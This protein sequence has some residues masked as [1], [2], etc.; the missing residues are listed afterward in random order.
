MAHKKLGIFLIVLFAVISA[1]AIVVRMTPSG[2][3]VGRLGVIGGQTPCTGELTVTSRPVD[4]KCGLQADLTMQGCQ[5]K[6][7]YVFEGGSCSG[8][9]MCTGNVNEPT[10]K[11]RCSW[12]ADK[13]SHTFTLCAD[14]D[15]KARSTVSC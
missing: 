3:G 14:L 12:E 4:G 6:K 13:G 1:V 11:W 15:A 7:W 8:T 5:G 9:Y 10:S 2:E